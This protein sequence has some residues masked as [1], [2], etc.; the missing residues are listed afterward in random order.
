MSNATTTGVLRILEGRGGSLCDPARSLR[1]FAPAVT[2]PSRLIRE[3]CLVQG[4]TLTGP[5]RRKGSAMELVGVETVCGLTPKAFQERTPYANLTAIN[6]CERWCSSRH[7]VVFWL[8]HSLSIRRK[9]PLSR[10]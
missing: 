8:F 7:K 1:P 9:F 6:S 5:L 3:H 10:E 2:V 4:A